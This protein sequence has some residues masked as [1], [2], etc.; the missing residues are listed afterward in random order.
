M[1][2]GINIKL[3]KNDKMITLEGGRDQINDVF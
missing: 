3:E 1:Y 2:D